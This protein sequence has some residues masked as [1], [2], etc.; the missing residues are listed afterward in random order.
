MT[1]MLKSFVFV[2]TAL[3]LLGTVGQV[4]ADLTNGSFETGDLTGW[5]ASPTSLVSV[6]TSYTGSG[7]TFLPTDGNYFAVLSAGAGP[8]TFTLLS[9][10]FAAGAG[11]KLSFDQ[12]FQANDYL[13]YNDNAYA[14]LKASGSGATVATLFYSDVASVGDFGHTP[15]THVNYTIAAAGSYYIEFGV[16]N[17][18]DNAFSSATG[19][20]NVHLS[21]VPEPST[22]AVAGAA[23]LLGAGYS[24]R[25]RRADFAA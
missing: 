19:V 11:S 24:W 22:L 8:N 15:W 5:T 18:I 16:E 10:T 2:T 14:A 1:Q 3:V 9:Q 7:P 17:Y 13:P 20:D 25:R 6:V 12:F 4:R 23:I 21:S